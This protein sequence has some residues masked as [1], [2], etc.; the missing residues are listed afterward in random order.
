VL[1]TGEYL[2]AGLRDLTVLVLGLGELFFVWLW[3]TGIEVIVL[4]K[5]TAV[6]LAAYVMFYLLLASLSA[7]ANAWISFEYV[8]KRW[9]RKHVDAS[10]NR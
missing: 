2:T 1:V 9:C 7:Q 5:I 8:W 6:Q 4:N 3:A 10:S